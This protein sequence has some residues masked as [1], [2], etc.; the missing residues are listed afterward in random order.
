MMKLVGETGPARPRLG[1]PP[2]EASPQAE[3][4][5]GPS[6][7]E[8][9]PARV[10]K[11]DRAPAV[12]P[13][14]AEATLQAEKTGEPSEREVEPARVRKRDRAQAVRPPPAEATP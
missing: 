2:A 9:E 6:E 4:T 7:R 1:R 10:R 13:P 5:G 8:V 14:P 3:K 11:R 12:R